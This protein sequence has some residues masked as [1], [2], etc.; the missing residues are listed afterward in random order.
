MLDVGLELVSLSLCHEH[1]DG[2]SL[3]G[4]PCLAQK[5]LENRLGTRTAGRLQHPQ[6]PGELLGLFPSLGY[7]AMVLRSCQIGLVAAVLLSG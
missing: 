2:A 5:G 3:E 4:T 7:Q 1:G 6:A